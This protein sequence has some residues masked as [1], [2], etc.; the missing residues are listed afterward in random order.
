MNYE[1]LAKQI[2]QE[3]GGE[4]NINSVIHCVT[5]LRFKLKDQS[6]ANT[7]VIKDLDGVMTVTVSGGQYQV[8]I[9][10]QVPSVYA[11]ITK[12]IGDETANDTENTDDS[13]E[14]GSLFNK[15]VSLMSGIFMPVMGVLAA[16]GILKGFLVALTVLDWMSE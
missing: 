13:V 9:G 15:F 4:E 7:E 6:L 16:A 8:V 12:L 5:R 2:V 14:G 11:E 10:D 3:V 1:N